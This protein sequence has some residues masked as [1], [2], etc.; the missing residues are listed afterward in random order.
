MQDGFAMPTHVVFCADIASGRLGVLMTDGP[1]ARLPV[2]V[3]HRARGNRA[4]LE[5]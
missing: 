2:F 1:P 3:I 5:A 4:G